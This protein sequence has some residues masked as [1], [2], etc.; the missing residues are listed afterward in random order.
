MLQTGLFHCIS[1]NCSL[2]QSARG[3]LGPA[4]GCHSQGCK[5]AVKTSQL[6]ACAAHL[7]KLTTRHAH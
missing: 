4:L 5:A 7:T 6:A 1:K 2:P 3:L